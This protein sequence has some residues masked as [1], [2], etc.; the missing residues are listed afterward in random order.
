M[1]RKKCLLAIV[2]VALIV[3]ISRLIWINHKY[4]PVKYEVIPYGESGEAMKD[5]KVKI[6]DVKEYNQ[7]SIKKYVEKKSLKVLDIANQESFFKVEVEMTNT[8]DK[9]IL[10]DV[11]MM[12]IESVGYSN[13]IDLILMNEWNDKWG[14]TMWIAP[15]SSR[16]LNLCYSVC[17]LKGDDSIQKMKKDGLYVVH[18]Y[19]PV[20]KMWKLYK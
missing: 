12:T 7:D 13:A 6:C 15:N 14:R 18:N 17:F 1:T 8:S 19:Y 2:L 16:K 4:P 3:F 10:F 20:K 9:E 11:G 5:I